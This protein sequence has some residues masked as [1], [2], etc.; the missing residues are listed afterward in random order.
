M[1][2]QYKTADR[3]VYEARWVKEA[4]TIYSL[5]GRKSIVGP[6]EWSAA[7]GCH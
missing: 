7:A 6:L 2:S 4:S 5:G 1:K 3:M